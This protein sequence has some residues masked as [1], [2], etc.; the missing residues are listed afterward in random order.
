MDPKHVAAILICCALGALGILQISGNGGL[1]G[2]LLGGFLLLGARFYLRPRQGELAL[3]ARCAGALVAFVAALVVVLFVAWESAEV[4]VLRYLDARGVQV[5]T[6]L[7]VI[8]LE[9][10]PSVAMGSG[11]RRVAEMQANPK[12]E[13]V[14]GGRAECRM[15]AVIA[16]SAAT[17]QQARLAERLFEE[18]YG[19]RLYATRALRFVMGAPPGEEPVLIRL[20]PCSE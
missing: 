16:G 3:L 4:V 15:A 6:R 11:K 17:E 18:K 1:I 8:D 10:H 20:E 13:L 5:E 12:V 14:R 2:W 9:G 7:W 19:V